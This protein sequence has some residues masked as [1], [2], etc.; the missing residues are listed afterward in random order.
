MPM[1]SDLMKQPA[2]YDR[3]ST[4]AVYPGA[5]PCQSCVFGFL[6]VVECADD[7]GRFDEFFSRVIVPLAA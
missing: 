7:A 1:T 6:L 3:V 5:R 4:V 2:M